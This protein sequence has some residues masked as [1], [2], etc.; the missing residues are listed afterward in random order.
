[1][2]RY[3][4]TWEVKNAGDVDLELWMESSTDT[5]NARLANPP[6]SSNKRVRVKPKG[7]TL[8]EIECRTKKVANE[9]SPVC[10]IGTNDPHR[11][12]FTLRLTGM[13]YPA[14]QR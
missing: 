10:S 5:A 14:E 4:H 9:F 8:V 3:S 12:L 2:Q 13:V 1:M 6:D 11:P 7:T